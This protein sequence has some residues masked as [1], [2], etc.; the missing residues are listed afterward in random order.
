MSHSRKSS[1]VGYI[2]TC[3]QSLSEWLCIGSLRKA[4][5]LTWAMTLLYGAFSSS[6]L[7]SQVLL[8]IYRK[9]TFIEHL[10][11]TSFTT[12]TLF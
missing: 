12:I 11:C 6:A 9:M 5:F 3:W 2:F 1:T 10:V 4:V 7:S 8:S